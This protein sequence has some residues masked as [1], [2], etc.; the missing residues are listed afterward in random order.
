MSKKATSSNSERK[1]PPPIPLGDRGATN[2]L[3]H[4]QRVP[5]SGSR[6]RRN[7]FSERRRNN[8]P[9][10]NDVFELKTTSSSGLN[11]E[12][13]GFHEHHSSIFD[14]DEEEVYCQQSDIDGSS[15]LNMSIGARAALNEHARYVAKFGID[16]E[17]NV[18]AEI[19]H[20][21]K[22][23]DDINSETR[24]NL[25]LDEKWERLLDLSRVASSVGGSSCEGI[26]SPPTSA[27]MN[28]HIENSSS[29]KSRFEELSS[30]EIMT[31]VS[32]D[33][34]NSSRVNLLV[35]PERNKNRIN[36]MV[37]TRDG[38]GV[39]DAPLDCTSGSYPF[40]RESGVLCYQNENQKSDS[41]IEPSQIHQRREHDS[42]LQGS[43]LNLGDISRISNNTLSDANCT[44]DT[45]FHNYGSSSFTTNFGTRSAGSP[46]QFSSGSNCK[47]RSSP[48]PSVVRQSHVEKDTIP[49][50]RNP[51]IATESESTEKN[52]NSSS[53][54]QSA[55]STFIEEARTFARQVANDVEKSMEGME[56]LPANFLRGIEIGRTDVPSPISQVLSSPSTSR[57]DGL[58]KEQLNEYVNSSGST[59]DTN[60]QYGTKSSSPSPAIGDKI[61]IHL[62]GRKR[63]RTVVPRRV[64][65]LDLP[66]QHFNDEQDS[67]VAVQSNPETRRTNISLLESFEEVA[68]NKTF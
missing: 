1:A 40:G 23:S 19:S 35:T 6:R 2:S 31:D 30:M 26:P 18:Q 65:Y 34:F 36:E 29:E 10:I 63:Y 47:Q 8:F 62:A 66:S 48:G 9:D 39:D 59:I 16:G 24:T 15:V 58:T 33:F 13:N 25:M 11:N 43:S 42:E 22:S 21:S 55:I 12:E 46:P 53:S 45:S 49:A 14:D 57:Q 64:Y 32:H 41:F 52:V 17:I 28:L 61:Q 7:P 51:I 50:L 56:S 38:F 27:M 4:E 60:A 54:F 68:T 20:A 5:R 67:F 44:P 3:I 37:I